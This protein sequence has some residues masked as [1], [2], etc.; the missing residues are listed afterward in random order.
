[1]RPPTEIHHP[2]TTPPPPVTKRRYM[3]NREAVA[4]AALAG[5]MLGWGIS[6]I[7]EQPPEPVP[8]VVD[9]GD[10]ATL[11]RVPPDTRAPEP[12]KQVG[13]DEALPWTGVAR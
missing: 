2:P 8:V 5:F 7:T 1:M 3:P 9:I 6:T 13:G 4:L 10:A 12:A 11:L